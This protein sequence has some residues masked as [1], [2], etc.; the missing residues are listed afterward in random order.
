MFMSHHQNGDRTVLLSLYMMQKYTEILKVFV[1]LSRK[2]LKFAAV[3]CPY[4]FSTVKELGLN[5][6]VFVASVVMNLLC[7]LCLGTL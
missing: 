1:Y 5:S 2:T 6:S 7:F 3:L 4:L